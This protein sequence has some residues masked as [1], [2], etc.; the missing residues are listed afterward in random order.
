MY[1][2]NENIEMA[3][4]LA[5][6]A[7]EMDPNNAESYYILG[8][9]YQSK[10]MVDEALDNY[11]TALT[12]PHVNN[13]IYFNIGVMYEKKKE[14]K[15]AVHSYKQ[16]LSLDQTH[17]GAAIHLAAQLAN[18]GE[19]AKAKKYFKHCIKLNQNSVPAHF[20]IG[21]ILHH[22]EEDYNEALKH[23]KIVTSRDQ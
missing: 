9:V 18:L 11:K 1:I 5:N 20:G 21:K 14:F 19:Y 6:E 13:N 22:A 12:Y 15:E 23:Y 10:N 7:I 2:K 16:C 17:F 3:E 4:K 8:K